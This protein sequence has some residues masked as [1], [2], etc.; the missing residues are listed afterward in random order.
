MLCRS[1]ER[2]GFACADIYHA[3]NG[4][5][6]TKAS[7][8]LLAEDYTHPSNQGNARIARVL[9]AQGFDSLQ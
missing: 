9:A 3:F 6:G 4:P 5:D 8:S 7:G 2:H 1:A